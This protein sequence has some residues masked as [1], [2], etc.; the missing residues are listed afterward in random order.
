MKKLLLIL[1]PVIAIML[2]GCKDNGGEPGS[3]SHGINNPMDVRSNGKEFVQESQLQLDIC[4]LKN[5]AQTLKSLRHV[6]RG[7]VFYMDYDVQFPWEELINSDKN[8]RFPVHF[9]EGINAFN[10]TVD[11]IFFN[12]P[13]IQ[14][15]YIDPPMGCSGFVCKNQKGQ[16]LFGRNLDGI[17]GIM[18]ILFVKNPRP[19][20][21]KSVLFTNVSYVQRWNG[22]MLYD[23]DGSLL[24]PTLDLTVLL[25]QNMTIMDG[26]N[27]HGLC[28]AAYQL[29]NNQQD[30][31][32][33]EYP[34]DTKRPI[35]IDQHTGKEQL[36]WSTLHHK[37]LSTCKTVKDVEKLFKSHDYT[38]LVPRTNI[39]WFVAD[40]NNDFC[41]FEYWNRY[42]KVNET[43]KD[44]LYV[45][46]EDNRFIS[47]HAT[48][49]QVPYERFCIEN[50]YANP[51]ATATFATDF[52]QYQFTQKTRVH[53]MMSG[54]S[55]VMS[56]TQALECLQL[57]NFG[58]N[59]ANQLTDWSCVY[60][61]QEMTILFNM[62][63]D[64]SEV[65]SIDVKKDLGLQ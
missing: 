33:I 55:P 58:M 57:G 63:D 22:S 15:E 64:M 41:I 32:E 5:S 62:R 20:E 1:T 3:Y 30:S 14:G 9:P 44:T 61:P 29:P 13:M 28:L 45:L 6:S 8:S 52:W 19:N 40:A 35:A 38:N 23:N 59:N 60:N 11:E 49:I 47:T 4:K 54:Y 18:V 2:A 7:H 25:R 39:H 56:E 46:D 10:Q 43:W 17:P 12:K 26:I 51:E 37:I 31:D 21:Y 16:L 65:Y 24:D 42:D 53:K 36:V 50:Y 48:P 34:N 27:E